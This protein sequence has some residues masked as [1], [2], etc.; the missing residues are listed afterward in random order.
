MKIKISFA[1]LIMISLIGIISSQSLTTSL[2][3][4][5][6]ELNDKITTTSLIT[7]EKEVP[8]NWILEIELYSNNPEASVPRNFVK[9]IKLA[10]EESETVSYELS[11]NELVFNGAY[12]MRI[13]LLNSDDYKLISKSSKS[14]YL[15]GALN[16]LHV[17]LVSSK[18]SALMQKSK[19]FIIGETVNLNYNADVG[20]VEV[21]AVLT[22]PDKSI[23]QITLPYSMIAEKTGIYE[24][25]VIAT[26][27]DY[28]TVTKTSQFAVLSKNSFIESVSMCNSNRVCGNNENYKTCPQDCKP[29]ITKRYPKTS[30]SVLVLVLLI[31]IYALK[32]KKRFLK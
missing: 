21:A 20:G 2:D 8:V 16:P 17:N 31:L 13:R 29:G 26:K 4:T 18:D 23:K 19:S 32:N 28:P 24:L 30:V 25:K 3:K 1:V 22:Y 10:P 6:Y 12:Q 14:F 9:Y 15:A 5:T 27:Q 7:N 11:T